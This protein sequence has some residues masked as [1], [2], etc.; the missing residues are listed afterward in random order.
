[1]AVERQDNVA[2]RGKAVEEEHTSHVGAGEMDPDLIDALDSVAHAGKVRLGL[3]LG[4][5]G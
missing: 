4:L 3:G 2:L 1:M 5:S